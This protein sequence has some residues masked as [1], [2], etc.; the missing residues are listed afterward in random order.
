MLSNTITGKTRLLGI[1]AWPTDHVK[2]PPAINRI[3]AERGRDTVMVP[4]AVHPDNFETVVS[5]FRHIASL[6]GC[7]VTVPHK[8][9]VLP[10]C[11]SL[12]EQARA[13]GAVN[14]LQRRED[15]HLHGGQL[16]GIGFVNGLKAQGV[17]PAGKCVYLVGAG[18]AASAI[19]FALAEAGVASLTLAN[20]SRHKIEALKIRLLTFRPDLQVVIGDADPSGNDII[21]NGTTLGMHEGDAEPLQFSSL[22]PEMVV[23]E[24][25]MEPR[26]TPLL[27]AAEKAGC[28]IHY[29]S[30]MLEHQLQLMA[31]FMK[32]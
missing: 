9:A 29:G 10:L 21:I 14:I 1:L 26:M 28:R 16:D 17:D 19:A 7:I 8:Q 22:K 32:L 3:A 27:T 15:G 18:G 5:S 12:T 31:D 25:I 13:V 11:D 30:H 24:V 2:A 4:F 20:R 23:A 6:D